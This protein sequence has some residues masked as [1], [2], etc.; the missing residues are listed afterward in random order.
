[1]DIASRILKVLTKHNVTAIC[2]I[3]KKLAKAN[4]KGFSE[5]LISNLHSF[6]LCPVFALNLYTR[7][8]GK[9]DEAECHDEQE[10]LLVAY[11]GGNEP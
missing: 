2:D 8:N 3:A 1:M 7:G 6:Y 4:I 11:G 5:F 10:E 9:G